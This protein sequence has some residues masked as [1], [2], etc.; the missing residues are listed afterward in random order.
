MGA[1]SAGA[2]SD[3]GYARRAAKGSILAAFFVP[4][5]VRDGDYEKK[6]I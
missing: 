2:N 4:Y 1:Q 5:H 3:S 6:Q